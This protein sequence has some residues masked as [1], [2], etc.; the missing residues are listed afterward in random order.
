LSNKADEVNTYLSRDGGLTWSEIAKGSHT[1][2]IGDHGSLLLMASNQHAV[3]EVMLSW[4][5]GLTWEYLKISD[6]PIEVENIIIEPSNT[7]EKFVI[8]GRAKDNTN[9]GVIIATDFTPRHQRWCK[10]PD[11]PNTAESDYETWTPNGKISPFCLL[12]RQVNYIRKKREAECFNSEEHETWKFIKPCPCTEEDWECDYGYTRTGSGPCLPE[13]DKIAAGN[14]VAPEQ[15]YGHYSITQGYRKVGGNSCLGGVDH[16]PIMVQCPGT[17][18]LS[19]KNFFLMGF[20]LFGVWGLMKLSNENNMQKAKDMVNMKKAKELFNMQKVKDLFDM[21]KSLIASRIPQS[22]AK[23]PSGFR[24]IDEIPDSLREDDGNDFANIIFDDHEEHENHI[25]VEEDRND[26][27]NAVIEIVKGK[28]MTGRNG[29]ETA[30]K[31]VPKLNKPKQF[32][33]TAI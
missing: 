23:G 17:T 2:E 21:L 12:G 8:Y 3:T 29:Y 27:E 24:R 6:T 19:A 10:N 30:T 22:L 26:E 18:V 5:E 13:N 7:A 9:K 1:Y 11:Q 31:H 25:A 14:G 33:K 15:C 32:E 4:N 16:S 28:R 20:L